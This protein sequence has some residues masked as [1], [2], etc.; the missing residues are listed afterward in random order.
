MICKKCKKQIDDDSEFCEFCG[1]KIINAINK[2]VETPTKKLDP[3]FENLKS[4]PWYRLLKVL[5][6]VGFITSIF[7]AISKIE[8]NPTKEFID[9]RNTN[10]KCKDGTIHHPSEI[11]LDLNKVYGLDTLYDNNVG[12]GYSASRTRKIARNTINDICRNNGAES[13][14]IEI[15]YKTQ[16]LGFIAYLVGNILFVIIVFEIIRQIGYYIF[17]GKIYPH[18]LY[19]KFFKK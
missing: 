11:G 8:I 12:G 7:F 5:Y 17:L 4:R 19:A 10:V 2:I 13:T 6:I 9:N 16:L 14:S 3:N 18:W 15:I 1:A